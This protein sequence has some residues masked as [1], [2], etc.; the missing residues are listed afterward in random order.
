MR[1]LPQK[2]LRGSVTSVD[3]RTKLQDEPPGVDIGPLL[4][5]RGHGEGRVQLTA[6]CVTARDTMPSLTTDEG[7][8]IPST[9]YE[10][11]GRRVVRYKFS[12]KADAEAFYELDGERRCV[13]TDFGQDL[14]I[15][16]VSCNGQED[17][18]LER[19]FSERNAMWRRLACQHDDNPFQLLLHGGDQIYADEILSSHPLLRAWADEGEKHSL[20]PSEAELD[21]LRT[22]VRRSFIDCYSGVLGSDESN[23]LMGRVPSLTMWDDHDIC[24]GWGSMSDR[25]LDA[26]VGRLL[27]EVARE[28]FLVFQFGV[29]PDEVPE[30]V[31]DR[32]ASTLTW[33]VKLTGLH[34]I[35]P[36]LRSERRRRRVMGETGWQALSDALAAVHEGRV[37]L[38]SS[39]PALGPRLSW[40]EG[41]MRLWPDMQKYEDDLRDQWQSR[42]HRAE[43]RRLLESLAKVHADPKTPVTVLSGEIHLATRGTFDV[44]PTPIHQLVASGI[45][46]PAPTVLY[47]LGLDVLARFGETPVPGHEIRM[48]PLPGRTSIYT[49]QRNFLVLERRSGHWTAYWEL[50]KSG[51]TPPLQM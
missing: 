44:S 21:E 42:A 3:S 2:A 31:I 49:S 41:V 14:R 47:A 20:H 34:V 10:C 40:I 50:E 27:F 39:V 18:D 46:H 32:T 13:N 43:W 29:A 23:W 45:S 6:I 5:L 8:S 19:D 11:E 28:C 4:Y 16:F 33:H 30:I 9:I 1:I 26:P 25:K 37:L 48:R 35:A 7:R 51:R 22:S 15:A 36:D 17:G 38:I 24:D 12:L